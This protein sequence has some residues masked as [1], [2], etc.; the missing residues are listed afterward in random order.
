MVLLYCMPKVRYLSKSYKQKETS[1][2]GT[3]LGIT[4]KPESGTCLFS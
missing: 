3:A 1:G 2:M 4:S